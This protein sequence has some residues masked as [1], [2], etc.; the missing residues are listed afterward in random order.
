[1]F[2]MIFNNIIYV[3]F[4]CTYK[5]SD[6]TSTVNS[7][8]LMLLG[9]HPEIQAKVHEELDCI[10]GGSNRPISCDDL[11]KMVYLERVVKETMRIFPVA[12]IMAKVVS[13]DIPLGKGL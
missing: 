3:F 8:A 10:F 13:E 4:F 2:N 6:S 9:M 1:M 5:G 11:S 12:P 7:F